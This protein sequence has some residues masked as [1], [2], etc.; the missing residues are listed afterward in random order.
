MRR[1]KMIGAFAL[2][3]LFATTGT[4]QTLNWSDFRQQVLVY[5]PQSRQADLLREQ[6][7]SNLLRAR[8]GFDPKAFAD[9]SNKNFNGNNYFQFAEAGL[10][11]P[12]WAGLELKGAYNYASG[13]YLNPENKL[14]KS[15]QAN[16]GLEWS[17]GQG[18]LFDERRADLQLA[19]ANVDMMASERLS[20]QNDL[21]LESAK[22]YWQWV[23]EVQALGITEEALQQA[24]I[25]HNGLTESFRQGDKPAIDTLESFMQVQ[26]RT[27]DFQFARTA[28]QNAAIA[29]SVFRW[30]DQGVQEDPASLA[31]APDLNTIPATLAPNFNAE[32]LVQQARAQ[33]PDIQLYRVKMRQ[34]S[35]ERRLKNELR[36]PVVNLSY[37]LLGNG[38]T[39]FPTAF[40]NGAGVLANDVKWGLDVSYPLLNRK[41]RGSYQLTQIKMAQTELEFQWKTEAVAAKV[42]QYAN[43]WQNLRRQVTLFR[44]MTSNARR[45]LEAENEKFL[46]GES[47]I[48]LINT[49]E[50]RWLDSQLKL[51]KLQ[52]ELQKTEAGLLWAQGVLAQ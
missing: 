24:L 38:W 28:A 23:Y 46:Q 4:A 14:P 47:S 17:L 39:F 50:Q 33:H 25:R 44:D 43:D 3:L 45:L 49:R 34:L 15:G 37:Y 29:L 42:R 48:F 19:R 41:A 7:V 32:D 11:L 35:T 16:F 10:K 1:Y 31:A 30:N 20:Q 5:H 36:K 18:L 51:L 6:A 2:A 9:Y 8:G 21:L 12:T 52:A 27:L 40:A 26:S 22:T 13:E